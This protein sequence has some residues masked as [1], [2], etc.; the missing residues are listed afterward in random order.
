MVDRVEICM[1]LQI[2][3]LLIKPEWLD[4]FF[5]FRILVGASKHNASYFVFTFQGLSNSNNNK[6]LLLL[7]DSL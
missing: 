6:S 5:T 2:R 3:Q 4:S 1:S 7:F